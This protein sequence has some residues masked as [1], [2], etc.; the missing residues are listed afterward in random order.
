MFNWAPCISAYFIY[1]GKR[2][3][4]DISGGTTSASNRLIRQTDHILPLLTIDKVYIDGPSS[5]V[6]LALFERVSHLT[7][8]YRKDH[9]EQCVC[10]TIGSENFLIPKNVLLIIYSSISSQATHMVYL[11]IIY[12]CFSPFLP[13]LP[14]SSSL[15]RIDNGPKIVVSNANT[16]QRTL[17]K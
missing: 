8:F 13:S 9:Q 1:G 4:S 11:C 7:H 3:I 5:G 16:K 2:G 12:L 14:S 10:S 15:S 17:Y 6:L